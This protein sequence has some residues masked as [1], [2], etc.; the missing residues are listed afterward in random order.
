VQGELMSC[1]CEAMQSRG[2]EDEFRHRLRLR[3]PER[4]QR[5]MFPAPSLFF[6]S[7]SPFSFTPVVWCGL[8]ATKVAASVMGG[9]GHQMSPFYRGGASMVLGGR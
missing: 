2:E 1:S 4:R 3:C 8:C 6:S 9:L 7:S 5:L